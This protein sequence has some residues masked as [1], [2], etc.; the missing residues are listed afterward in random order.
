MRNRIVGLA[1]VALFSA[2][3][4]GSDE[5]VPAAAREE[6][7]RAARADSVARSEAL[8]DASVFDT[9]TWDSENSR[10]ERGGV[11]WTFTCQRCHG[12]DGKGKGEDAIKFD[13]D[14]PDI[15]VADW[16]YAGDIPGIRHLIFVGHETEMPSLGLIGLAYSDVDAA[17]HYI[18]DLLRRTE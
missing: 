1:L 18:D 8:Y 4:G 6:A 5:Q 10:W 13:M 11:V 16:P 15:T 9:I 2:C 12:S 7:L 3:G 14:V 17:A